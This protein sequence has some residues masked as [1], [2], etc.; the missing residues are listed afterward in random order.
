MAKLYKF[1]CILLAFL[2]I[3]F[4]PSL[5]QKPAFKIIPLGVKGGD[6]ESN[7]SS[8]LV[9]ANGSEQYIALDAGTIHAGLKK[10]IDRKL[11]HGTPESVERKYIKGYLIS[12]AHLDHLAGLIINSP[13]DTNKNIYALPSVI[14]ILKEKYFTWDAW[15]N[16]ANEG[17]KPAIGKYTYVPLQE[18]KPHPLA[19]TN[20]QATAFP[21][22]HVNPYQSTAFLLQSQNNYLLYL[23]DTGADRIEKSTKLQ[24]LWQKVAPIIASGELKALFLEVSFP[25]TQPENQLFGHLT[26]KLFFEELK[27]LSALTGADALKK[28]QIIITHRKPPLSKEKEIQ[29]ELAE[30]NTENYQL[31][32]PQQAKVIS[33]K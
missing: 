26:P 6:D 14:K 2:C 1:S 16:F 32:Y 24:Q 19:N 18:Q 20:L 29:K 4:V 3:N 8:Y 9:A 28:V 21:L 17:E 10:A 22:S 5:A 30:G 33:L 7:L 23:G 13:A 11:F 25:N 15:A 12:H 27:N 31:I